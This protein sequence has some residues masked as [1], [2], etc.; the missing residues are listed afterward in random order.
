[1]ISNAQLTPRAAARRV[2]H[3]SWAR[4]LAQHAL[5]MGAERYSLHE[6]RW[7]VSGGC[8]NP[9]RILF[10]GRPEAR[11]FT[12]AGARGTQTRLYVHHADGFDRDQLMS[13]LMLSRCRRCPRCLKARSFMWAQRAKFELGNSARTWFGTLTLRAEE[14]YL[15]ELRA[16]RDCTARGVNFD[17]LS[18]EAQFKARHNVISSELTLWLKRVRKQSGAS[19]RYLLVAEAHK[20]GLPH[21]HCLV[22]EVAESDRIGERVLR[23]QWKL[24]YSKFSLVDAGDPRAAR[25]VCKYL[26]KAAEARVRASVRYGVSARSVS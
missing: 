17:E 8:E 12:H 20:S 4:A 21:Y 19:A 7:D 6:V 18:P 11:P 25:Y 2:V 1:M 10:E 26:S 3:S 5:T 24:G 14:H 13:V 15:A 16:R 23:G 9:V 22:H